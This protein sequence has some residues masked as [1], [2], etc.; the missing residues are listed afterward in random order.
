M[1][2]IMVNFNFTLVNY[3]NSCALFSSTT[4]GMGHQHQHTLV[5]AIGCPHQMNQSSSSNNETHMYKITMANSPLA[6]TQ[7]K[8]VCNNCIQPKC[9]CITYLNKPSVFCGCI[10][11]CCE[12]IKDVDY[13]MDIEANCDIKEYTELCDLPNIC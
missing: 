10:G 13:D 5:G 3:A 4:A 8:W 1:K 6:I 2:Q 11:F 9:S 7:T 12:F